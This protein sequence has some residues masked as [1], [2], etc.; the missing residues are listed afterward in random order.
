MKKYLPLSLEITGSVLALAT[1]NYWF[2]LVAAAGGAYDLMFYLRNRP[3][4]GG[5]K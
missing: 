5:G 3:K 2:F 4:S 1:E